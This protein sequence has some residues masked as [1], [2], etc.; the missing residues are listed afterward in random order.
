MI[1]TSQETRIYYSTISVP[2]RP[3]SMASQRRYVTRS[4]IRTDHVLSAFLPTPFEIR[5]LALYLYHAR[6]KTGSFAILISNNTR[7]VRVKQSLSETIS[8]RQHQTK[9]C[10]FHHLGYYRILSRPKPLGTKGGLQD[11]KPHNMEERL[12]KSNKLRSNAKGRLTLK[13]CFTQHIHGLL[14]FQPLHW[15]HPFQ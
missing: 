4:T 6:I 3:L 2:F 8:A 13:V 10:L 14:R 1:S 12:P 15:S 11:T 7:V 9:D 5:G